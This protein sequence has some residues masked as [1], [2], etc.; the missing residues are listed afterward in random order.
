MNRTPPY[1]AVVESILRPVR[2]GA[3]Q[4]VVSV[5]TE[6]E[7]L[8]RPIRE[9]TPWEIQRIEVMLDAKDIHVVELGREIA[10]A[11]AHVRADTGLRL[12]DATIVATARYA[13]CDVIVGND[14][15]CAQRVRDIP[16]VL[17]DELVEER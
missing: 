1:F 4:A 3:K 6:I 17:L 14:A 16:Y 5:I 10:R 8:V 15:R 13:N 12:A 11:A 2:D 7:L 9:T